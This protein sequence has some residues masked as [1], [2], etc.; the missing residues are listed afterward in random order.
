MKGKALDGM[1]NMLRKNDKLV[2]NFSCM[3]D[4]KNGHLLQSGLSLRATASSR[5]GTEQ[6]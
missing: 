1:Y 4:T 6:S 3:F 5:G 2:E